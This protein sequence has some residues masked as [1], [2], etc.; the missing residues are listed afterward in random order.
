ML[1][2]LQEVYTAFDGRQFLDEK[3]CFDYEIELG[4]RI[5]FKAELRDVEGNCLPLTFFLEN[6]FVSLYGIRFSRKEEK[7]YF[8]LIVEDEPCFGEIDWEDGCLHYVYSLDREIWIDAEEHYF[9]L[10]RQAEEFRTKWGV[11][12]DQYVVFF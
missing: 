3:E 11:D 1:V 10:V 2:E 8:R 6:G 5:N 7:E 12:V 9:D 4:K